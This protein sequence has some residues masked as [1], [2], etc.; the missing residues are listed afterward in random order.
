MDKMTVLKFH[1][2]RCAPCKTLAPNLDKAVSSF[3]NIT[4]E[5]INIDQD[6]DMAAKYSVRM[7]PTLV[8]LKDGEEVG[9]MVG[10]KTLEQIVSFLSTFN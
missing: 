9:R 5:S 10:S 8:L 2:P 4:V 6:P 1:A 3:G 7:I